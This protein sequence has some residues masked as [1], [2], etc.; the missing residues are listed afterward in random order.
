M[1]SKADACVRITVVFCGLLVSANSLA[2]EPEKQPATVDSSNDDALAQLNHVCRQAYGRARTR[3]LERSGPIVVSIGDDLILIDGHEREPVAVVPPLFHQL[4]AVSHVPLA[5]FGVLDESGG[6]E[7]SRTE[8]VDLAS[9]QASVRAAM[10]SLP[11]FEFS[12]EQLK[13][14]RQILES[15][16]EF[17]NTALLSKRVDAAAVTGFAR[18]L[19]DDLMKNSNEAA[20]L[21]LDA[22]DRQMRVWWN[23]LPAANR[24]KFVAVVVGASTPRQRN[25][26]VQFFAHVIGVKGEGSRIIYAESLF[27]V[28]KA[29]KLCGTHL[30]DSR[31]ASGFF[32]DDRRMNRDLFSDFAT[33]Y[34]RNFKPYAL[35]D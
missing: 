25:L 22:Y 31:V 29:L 19:A 14:Q 1:K 28:E 4:K 27:D 5:I 24:K 16:S 10:I 35:D 21:K 26:A 7:L 32:A 6:Q 18:S 8:R 13:R 33:V 15:S 12:Q 9:I 17:I 3:L 11:R 23:Q 20:Q 34:L 2:N 30:I